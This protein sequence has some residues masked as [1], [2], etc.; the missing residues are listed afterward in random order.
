MGAVSR[1]R[2]V[3]AIEPVTRPVPMAMAVVMKFREQFG[4][5]RLADYGVGLLLGVAYAASIGGIA[6]IIGTP[7]NLSFRRILTII[8]PEAPETTSCTVVP[9][10]TSS[11]ATPEMM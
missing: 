5:D 10:L 4:A 9:T 3:A 8:F 7:P 6:T 2:G 11:A 1:G